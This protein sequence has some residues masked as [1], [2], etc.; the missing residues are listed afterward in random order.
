MSVV[1]ACTSG[2]GGGAPPAQTA[3]PRPEPAGRPAEN[4]AFWYLPVT[5][6][7]QMRRLGPVRLVVAGPQNIGRPE[8]AAHIRA[9]GPEAYLYQQTYWF[10]LGRRYQGL[11]IDRHPE[12]AFCLDGDTPL[13]VRR[14]DGRDWWY[15]DMNERAVQEHLAARFA[16]LRRQ[17]WDGVFFDRGL[18]ALTGYGQEWPP[19]WYR[20]SSCT[21]DPVRPGATFADTWI[22]VSALVRRAGLKLIVNYGQSPFDPRVPMRPDPRDPR[23]VERALGCRRL[24]DGWE[25]PTLIADEA[26]AHPRDADWANDFAAN[27]FNEQDPL[28]GG[29]VIGLI[30]AGTLGGDLSRDNVYFQWARVKLFAFPLGV[31]PGGPRRGLPPA[32][33]LPRADRGA[34]RPSPRP[35]APRRGLRR[36]LPGKLRVVPPLPGGRDRGEC[37]GP[38]GAGAP[39]HARHPGLPL[40]AR[41]MGGRAAGREPLRLRGDPRPPALVGAAARLPRPALVTPPAQRRRI[42]QE[43]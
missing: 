15:L 12:W 8:A 11:R 32:G 34:A 28:H 40:G 17:G 23:C 5:S 9:A 41:R 14:R 26:V 7:E 27:R 10:P 25:H 6:T 43:P 38:R 39:V 22:D 2:G 35:A 30:T 19:T 1:A 36:G 13:T 42:T 33:D 3:A 29:R 31:P 16:E 20:T 21:E 37:V 18:A 4:V 24:D